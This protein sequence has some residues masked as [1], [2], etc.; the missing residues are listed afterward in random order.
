MKTLLKY[1][2][3]AV[4]ATSVDYTLF[5]ILSEIFQLWYLLSSVA[6]LVAGGI[7][8][9][10]LE[11]S[12]A[13]EKSDGKISKQAVRYIITWV[14][15]ILLNSAGLYALVEYAGI[16]YIASKIIVSALVGIGFNFLMHKHFVFG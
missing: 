12:W 8:S 11:R 6:G 3:S 4:I 10:L 1:N 16:Q 9:F 15:S 5:I 14:I 13:F 2:T 7:T